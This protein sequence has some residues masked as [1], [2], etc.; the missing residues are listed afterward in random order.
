MLKCR[1]VTC[2]EI[3][4]LAWDRHKKCIFNIFNVLSK[5]INNRNDEKIFE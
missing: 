3:K 4:V 5:R 2:L 1:N